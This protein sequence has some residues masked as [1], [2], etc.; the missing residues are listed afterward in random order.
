MTLDQLRIFVAVAQREHVT[1]AA[2]A[3]NMTQSAVSGALAALEEQHS[4]KLF[5]RVGRG[6]RLSP[7]GWQFLA[8]AQKVLDAA[9]VAQNRLMEIGGAWSGCIAVHASHTVANYWL[10]KVLIEFGRLYPKVAMDVTVGNTQMVA[11]AV[12]DSRADIG[13]VEGDVDGSDLDRTVVAKDRMIVVVGSSHPWSRRPPRTFDQIAESKW[14][15]RERGSGTR[16]TFEAAM[17]KEGID[18]GCLTV[19]LE[20]PSNEAIRSALLDSDLASVMSH[21]VVARDLLAG[22]LH[23]I[24]LELPD[25]SFTL[26]KERGR[27]LPGPATRFLD[28]LSNWH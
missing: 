27:I 25:R 3:L 15:L 17:A 16:S 10:P 22:S 2:A 6:V 20:L 11:A 12:R 21:A 13:I 5:T 26:I 14:V 18:F 1:R 23:E 8:E 7:Q 9:Q 24:G 19:S 28:L 4:V